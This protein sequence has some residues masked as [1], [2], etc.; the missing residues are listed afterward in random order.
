MNVTSLE[1]SLLSR[2][3]LA[4]PE[5]NVFAV[6]PLMKTGMPGV[7]SEF[8]RVFSA[9]SFE[10]GRRPSKHYDPGFDM[11]QHVLSDSPTSI[12]W[13]MK[14]DWKDYTRHAIVQIGVCN[15]RCFYC[16]V[17]YDFLKGRNVLNVTAQDIVDKFIELREEA[18]QQGSNLNVLRI[19]GGEPLLVPDLIVEVL[20]IIK[21][22][23]LD[24]KIC[25]KTETNLSPL[26]TNDDGDCVAEKWASLKELSSYNNFIM[27]P[28]FHGISKE[29]LQRVSTAKWESFDMMV[30][31]VRK[32]IDL[33]IQFFPSF[34]SNV[35]ELED[36]SNF[37][38]L[39]KSI[40]PNL[41][42]RIAVR[43]FDVNYDAPLARNHGTRN[44]KVFDPIP[45]MQKWD[46]LLKK[47]Y[48]VGYGEVP[49][50]S[51]ELY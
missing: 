25:I 45:V 49:R 21:S 47:E 29:S 4:S 30:S 44:I 34:G 43:K 26:V 46:S 36:I 5:A 24:D 38:E 11:T 6:A 8:I 17:D 18:M 48:G 23:G 37:F 15:F 2:R 31:G 51:F 13:R 10:K 1:K 40:H 14:G 33:K 42:G 9:I 41:P 39:C 12:A 3:D 50:H 19:S 20:R 27:H 28:T 32:L 7:L 16:Y 35:Y 22:M